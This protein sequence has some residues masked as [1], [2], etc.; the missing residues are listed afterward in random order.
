MR[1]NSINIIDIFAQILNQK[2]N[3]QFRKLKKKSKI[4]TNYL[5]TIRLEVNRGR[6]KLVY[7][8]SHVPLT[9]GVQTSS[10]AMASS[11]L[12]GGE[13]AGGEG[14]GGASPAFTVASRAR[15]RFSC[16]TITDLS[17]RISSTK[18][19]NCFSCGERGW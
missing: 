15:I 6:I 13:G 18:S 2:R 4:I 11:W 1:Q 17:F 8:I 3:C 9:H 7:I 10:G 19:D 16:F 5:Y 12:L 14:A